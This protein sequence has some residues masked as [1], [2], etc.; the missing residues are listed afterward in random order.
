[1]IADDIKELIKTLKHMGFDSEFI[2]FTVAGY[3]YESMI[4][5]GEQRK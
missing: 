3:I 5:C 1:M 2:A 4:V